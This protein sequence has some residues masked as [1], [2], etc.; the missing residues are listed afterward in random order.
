MARARAMEKERERANPK[1]KKTRKAKAKDRVLAEFSF[2]SKEAKVCRRAS[3]KEIT[4]DS[5]AKFLQRHVL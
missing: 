3:S 4:L 2:G 1:P 5:S